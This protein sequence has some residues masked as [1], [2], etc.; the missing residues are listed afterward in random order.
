MEVGTVLEWYVAP[1]DEVKRGDVIALVDT[2]KAEIEVEIWQTGKVTGVLVEIGKQVPVGTPLLE[3]S[4]T[5]EAVAPAPETPSSPPALEAVP[6]APAAPPVGPTPTAEREPETEHAKPYRVSPFARQRAI[7]LGVELA[8]VTGSG[9]AGRIRSED[10]EQAARAI[11]TAGATGTRAAPPEAIPPAPTEKPPG[12][13]GRLTPERLAAVRRGMASAMARAKREIPHFHLETEIDLSPALDWLEAANQARPV[14]ERLLLTV[15]LLKAS[16]RALR[17]VPELNGHWIDGAF[18]PAEAVHLGVAI[19]VRGGGLLA[20]AL[21]DVDAMSLDRLM[22]ELSELAARARR[23]QLKS[24]EVMNATATVT[25]LG[26]RGADRVFGVIYPPQVAL[27]GFGAPRERAWAE[28]G[29]I[30]ARPVVSATLAADHRA[31]DGQRGSRLLAR[32]ASELAD[33]EGLA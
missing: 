10:V 1:G 22:V 7:E 13:S 3:L 9:P 14:K 16:A 32:I 31:S 5:G 12:E 6:E 29:K 2:E 20:P 11:G 17:R 4:E 19:A 24:S 15:L 26:D 27:V 30:S 33:P 21:A 25:S 18:R 23:A 8:D 28:A